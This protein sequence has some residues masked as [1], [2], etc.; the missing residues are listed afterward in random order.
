MAQQICSYIILFICFSNLSFGQQDM[1]HEYFNHYTQEDGVS[2]I[3]LGKD[4]LQ[5]MS[6]MKQAEAEEEFQKLMEQLTSLSILSSD[7]SQLSDQIYREAVS[8]MN[9]HNY[10]L[11][12]QYLEGDIKISYYRLPGSKARKTKELVMLSKGQ[13]N[14]LVLS[15]TGNIKL[16]DIG[17]L[18]R[19]MYLKKIVG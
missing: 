14:C 6:R 7:S 8:M 11:I 16:E 19:G 1:I 17:R 15:I 18:A 4:L 12:Q 3:Y 5:L 2:H 9:H 10:Q 13:N